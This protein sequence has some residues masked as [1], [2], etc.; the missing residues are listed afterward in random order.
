MPRPKA[1]E[2]AEQD[3]ARGDLG[4]ARQRLAS[5]LVSKGYDREIVARVGRL[6]LQMGDLAEA[7]RY[8]LLSAENGK[9]VEIAIS[10]FVGLHRSHP[11]QLLR[12]LPRWAR[13]AFDRFP[14]AVQQRLTALGVEEAAR[15]EAA[16]VLTVSSGSGI[17]MFGCLTG[18]ILLLVLLV[19]GVATTFRWLLS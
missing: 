9:D 11:R 8:L 7:G 15:A 19:V 12:Q 16:N 4:A 18:G 3:V 2:R 13:G 6:C 14:E 5:L 17:A 1:L 10:T